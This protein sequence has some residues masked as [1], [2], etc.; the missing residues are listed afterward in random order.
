M[1]DMQRRGDSD[2]ITR[3][4]FDSFLLETRLIGADLPD[5]TL[6][7][8]GERFSTPVMMAALSHLEKCHPGGMVEMARG[9]A[10]ANAVMWA[11]MG[12]EVELEAILATGAKTIKIIKPYADEDCIL[13]KIRHAEEHGALAVGM[14]I[15]HAF[16]RGGG[17]DVVRGN[18][19]RPK[20]LEDLRCYVASTKLPFVVKGVLS[21]QDALLCARAGVQGIVV[22]HHHGIMD[23]AVPP[24][25]ILPQ[26]VEAVG[27]VMP[28]FVD[29]DIESGMDAFKAMALGATAVSV[30]RKMMEYLQNDGA[31]G[32]QQGVKD[33]TGQLAGAMART[34][35]G[36][37]HSFDATVLHK[38]G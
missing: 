22:S 20:T 9:A 29:C 14:D 12:D 13:R 38:R 32:I 6:E 37:L 19:M 1:A 34:G 2:R 17:Y 27:Q 21:V 8:Y 31:R 5:T 24:L 23:Y 15:D 4:Y 18:P 33:I 30:G 7:L 28:V 36:D 35:T 16:S 10:A 11:G 3:E 25:Q 26:I